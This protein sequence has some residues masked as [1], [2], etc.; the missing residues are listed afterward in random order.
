MYTNIQIYTLSHKYLWFSLCFFLYSFI[1][2]PE[3]DTNGLLLQLRHQAL[4]HRSLLQSPRVIIWW[5]PATHIQNTGLENS[6]GISVLSTHSTGE[7]SSCAFDFC[8]SKIRLNEINRLRVLLV[9]SYWPFYRQDL[10]SERSRCRLASTRLFLNQLTVL[11]LVCVCVHVYVR[12]HVCVYMCACLSLSLSLCTCFYTACA[13]VCVCVR[14]WMHLYM[15]VCVCVCACAC[16]CVFWIEKD[17]NNSPRN[18]NPHTCCLCCKHCHTLSS[19]H[20]NSSS[21]SSPTH[22]SAPHTC[23][24]CPYPSSLFA[25]SIISSSL[26]FISSFSSIYVVQNILW[27][28]KRSGIE[29]SSWFLSLGHSLIL[30][31]SGKTPKSAL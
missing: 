31:A 29:R 14:I 27:G 20:P 5:S 24:L 13:C 22:A 15:C 19:F 1:S 6:V 18:T 28:M 2:Y 12:V 25:S 7:T 16:A 26:I 17:S 10:F 4:R 21:P 3:E 23:Y 11:Y 8:W 9:Y 30:C